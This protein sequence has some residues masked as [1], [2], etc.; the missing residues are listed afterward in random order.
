MQERYGPGLL[1]MLNEGSLTIFDKTMRFQYFK[2]NARPENGYTLVIGLHGGGN[3]A[4]EVNDTQYS[5][6]LH[7]YD[8]YMP[9]GVIWFVPRSCEEASDMWWKG[10]I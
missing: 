4:T 1:K 5:N 6:H 10:Y 3:C 2:K 8:R 7:L 9:P